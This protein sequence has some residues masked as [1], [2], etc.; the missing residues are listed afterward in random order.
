MGVAR[1]WV[2]RRGER[3]KRIGTTDDGIHGTP[4]NQITE[5]C[6]GLLSDFKKSSLIGI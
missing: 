4:N 3:S 6:I 1:K 5:C 2:K